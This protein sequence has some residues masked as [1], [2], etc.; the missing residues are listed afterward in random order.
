[1]G[2]QRFTSHNF[3]VDSMKSSSMSGKISAK[4]Q[5]IWME[6]VKQ[7][8]EEFEKLN[9]G[10]VASISHLLSAPKD[11]RQQTPTNEKEIVD[12]RPVRPRSP[13]DPALEIPGELIL[14]RSKTVRKVCYWPA[15]ILDYTEA[16]LYK[17]E[18]MDL[19]QDDIPRSMFFSA[20]QDEFGTCEVSNQSTFLT[21]SISWMFDQAGQIYFRKARNRERQG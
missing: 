14:A 17:V 15:H 2:Q 13:A 20:E 10:L 1:M 3:A 8:Q 6:A 16:G 4:I 18:Y 21:S 11:D 12:R 7:M 5:S 9:D 19:E